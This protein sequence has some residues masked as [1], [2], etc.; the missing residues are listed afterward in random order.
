MIAGANKL[1]G[2][3]NPQTI[4]LKQFE[5]LKECMESVGYTII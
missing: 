2:K 4:T 5:K 3:V 1:F